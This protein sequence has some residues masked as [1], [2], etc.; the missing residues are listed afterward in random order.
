MCHQKKDSAKK[1]RLAKV[2]K[3]QAAL[4]MKIDEE[5]GYLD[6]CTEIQ[7]QFPEE[8]ED[9]QN[10]QKPLASYITDPMADSAVVL[11]Y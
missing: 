4:M 7:A 8:G 11:W 2:A 9:T 1:R 3:K 5:F 10:L 6:E